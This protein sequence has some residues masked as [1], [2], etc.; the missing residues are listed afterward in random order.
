MSEYKAD[1]K[2]DGKEYTLVT[3]KP[4][5]NI[6][7]IAKIFDEKIQEVKS[8]K[9]TFDRALILAGLNLTDDLLRIGEA[10]KDLEEKAKTPMEEYPS[11]KEDR[12]RLTKENEDLAKGLEESKDLNDRLSS[13]K[14]ALEEKL[15]KLEDSTEIIEKLKTEVKR[16]QVELMELQRENESLK[17]SL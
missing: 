13:E 17:G 1:V 10:L 4:K 8:D 7:Q 6:R 12:E 14:S 3:D 15:S 11:L 9:L 2:I 16:L 5:E